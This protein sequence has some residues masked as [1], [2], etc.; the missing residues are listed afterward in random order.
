MRQ[1]LLSCCLALLAGATAAAL[2]QAAQTRTVHIT[3]VDA[4]GAPLATLSAADVAVKEG[5]KA[6]DVVSVEPASAPLKLVLIVDDNGSGLFR[7]SIAVFLNQ[8]IGHGDFAI[9]TINGQVQKIVDYTH[10]VPALQ[11]AVNRLGPRPATPDGGQLLEGIFE[12]AKDLRRREAVR[13]VI[14]VITVGGVEHSPL[15]ADQ[16]LDAL[17]DS[18]ARLHVIS[19]ASSAV[20]TTNT[21]SRPADLLD[22]PLNLAEVLGDGPKQSGGR[23]AE[24]VATAGFVLPLQQLAD[25]L[26]HQFVVTYT[27]PSGAKP[28]ERLSITPTRKNISLRAPTRIAVK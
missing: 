3:A 12:A 15:R 7:P 23:H 10:D 21:A 27:L 5:G 22:A 24:I 8:L 1:P 4:K 17:R 19:T 20:R 9:Q 6:R 11:G 18:Q 25:E 14:V 28:D 16:V 26:L 13:P 2:P